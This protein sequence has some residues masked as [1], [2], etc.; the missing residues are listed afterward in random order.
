MEAANI[1][2]VVNSVLQCG[3]CLDIYEDPRILTCGHTF[4]FKC[5][6]KQWSQSKLCAMCRQQLSEAII[7]DNLP[8]NYALQDVLES[9]PSLTKCV[10]DGD[11]Y[12]HGIAEYFCI[13]C[14]TTLCSFCHLAHKRNLL[15]KTHTLKPTNEINQED[16]DRHNKNLMAFCS[17]HDRQEYI[18]YCSYC[19][20]LACAICF[21]TSHSNNNLCKSIDLK[22]A[23]ELFVTSI[24][25]E[26]DEIES[27]IHQLS[28]FIDKIEV[29]KKSLEEHR[30]NVIL[31]SSELKHKIRSLFDF[32]DSK[33]KNSEKVVLENLN[34][35][36]GQAK[37]YNKQAEEMLATLKTNIGSSKKLLS[38]STAVERSLYVKQIENSS[39]KNNLLISSKLVHNEICLEQKALATSVQIFNEFSFD[40]NFC[41]I[42]SPLLVEQLENSRLKPHVITILFLFNSCIFIGRTNSTKLSVY[43]GNNLEYLRDQSL[44]DGVQPIDVKMLQNGNL[45][46]LSEQSKRVVLMTQTSRFIKQACFDFP[47][48]CFISKTNVIYLANSRDGIY[49]S[50]DDGMS[51]NQV[52]CSPDRAHCYRIIVISSVE[53]AHN[54]YWVCEN[55][56][57]RNYRLREYYFVSQQNGEIALRYNDISLAYFDKNN[58]TLKSIRPTCLAYDDGDYIYLCD[59]RENAVH[60]FNVKNKTRS[61]LLTSQD[62]LDSPR[63]L[64][65]DEERKRLYVGQNNGQVMLFSLDN[66]KWK[67]NLE[68]II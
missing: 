58:N 34:V 7:L 17:K 29:A 41:A 66:L 18:L 55:K 20:E 36:N 44:H 54:I 51:W 14:W 12:E 26:I 31:H 19:K 37:N 2:S 6:Q 38:S 30:T 59:R 67:Y 5:I 23:D 24:N 61:L 13:D 63:S 53:E 8:K 4:C 22:V 68:A 10:M 1:H 57:D 32:I 43:D 25:E 48:H 46:C 49:K 52:F 45:L 9:F 42:S 56:G 3:I 15:T 39:V 16:V 64:A 21:A 27:Q 47:V 65:I 62:K 28:E 35:A 33:I 50:A 60:V 40:W 11:G